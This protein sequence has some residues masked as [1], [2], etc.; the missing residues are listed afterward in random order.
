MVKGGVNLEVCENLYVCSQS[1]YEK[2][3]AIWLSNNFSICFCAKDPYHKRIVGYIK[4]LDK[5]NPEYLYAERNRILSLNM[6]DVDDVKYFSD[7]MINKAL[8]FIE[9]EIAKGYKVLVVCNKGESRSPSIALMYMLKHGF[10]KGY[11][12]FEMVKPAFREIYPNYLPKKGIEE[13]T[14]KFFE[15]LRGKN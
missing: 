6:I 4:N 3:D 2:M 11:G 7:K 15:N 12:T 1:E 9:S 5:S 8:E 13:Y 10:F 14:K